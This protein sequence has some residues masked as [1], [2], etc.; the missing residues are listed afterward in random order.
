MATSKWKLSRCGKAVIEVTEHLRKCTRCKNAMTAE[1]PWAM[2]REGVVKSFALVK[3]A[4]GL[5]V[6]HK[7]ALDNPDGVVY[8]CPDRMK[9]GYEYA[10]TAEP[11][12]VIAVQDRLL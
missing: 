11:V 8:P 7:H 5:S 1:E 2:C 9:H 12:Y 6:L 4:K 10:T 3:A